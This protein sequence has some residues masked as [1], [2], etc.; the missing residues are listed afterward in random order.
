MDRFFLTGVGDW[1]GESYPLPIP[2]DVPGP[3][4]RSYFF[5]FDAAFFFVDFFAA[6]LADLRF[7]AIP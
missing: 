7:M 2:A 1:Q 4:A 5:F 6:F 3:A